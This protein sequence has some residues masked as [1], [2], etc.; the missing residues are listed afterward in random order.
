[1]QR[2]AFAFTMIAMPV[3]VPVSAHEF[4]LEP[5]AYQIDADG[6]VQAAIVNGENF[7][8]VE[9]SYL[10][11]QF[12][13]FMQ[14]SGERVAP[15]MGR[16]GDRPALNVEPLGE[17]LQ[18][19]IYKSNAATLTYQTFEKFQRFAD[20]KDFADIADR[21]QERALPDADF[22]EVY[23]RYAKTLVAAGHG[24]GADLRTNL[25]TEFVAIT[26]PYDPVFM[27]NMSVQ[28]WYRDHVRANAQ[29]EVFEK[30]PDDSVNVSFYRTDGD[31]I[32]HFPV[33]PGYS[34]LVDAVVLRE[35]NANVV[36]ETGAVW[37]T[38]WASLTF[39]VPE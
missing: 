18:I 3:A 10:P 6:R 29:V 36:A 14:F 27:S 22:T 12:Q 38:L 8:G 5:S 19:F 13:L 1:M 26:N 20:H 4:W 16:L 17:G 33:K 32:A 9:L 24:E 39:E 34:Y 31:G 28:L 2:L 25:E 15:V 23:T 37:E 30:A 21:H 11:Q 35:P 7:D